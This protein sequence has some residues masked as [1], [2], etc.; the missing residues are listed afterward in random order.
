M[1][2]TAVPLHPIRKGS[3][4]KLWIALAV[5]AALAA[6]FAWWGTSAFQPVRTGSGVTIQTLAAG[7]GAKIT[8]QDV[9]ALHYKLHAKSLEAPVV[10]DSRAT[11]Q[12][13]VT[14][15]QGVYPGFGEGLRHMRPG[16]SYILTL[17]PGTH[18]PG[19]IPPGAPFTKDDSLVF[20]ID[21]LQVEPGA[22]PRYM[23]MQRMQ[24]MQQLQQM[25]QMQG[26]GAPG[27][28]EGAPPPAEGAR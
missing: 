19:P 9:V 21:V 28:P 10:E 24:Q 16:G 20:E 8:D 25:Q 27:G 5:L 13:F 14:T 3:V 23:E 26:G 12:P 1:S 18:V 2:V 7:S 22:G 17:P 6:A 4:A 11:G 15:T